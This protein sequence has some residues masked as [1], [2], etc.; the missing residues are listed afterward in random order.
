MDMSGILVS[1]LVYILYILFHIDRTVKKYE[2]KEYNFIMIKSLLYIYISIIIM[3]KINSYHN[4]FFYYWYFTSV[5]FSILSNY[6]FVSAV[7]IMCTYFILNKIE[8][9]KS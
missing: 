8:K 1:N 7:T 2:K 6:F 4:A 5:L 3:F 9:K